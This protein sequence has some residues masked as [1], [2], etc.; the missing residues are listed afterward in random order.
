MEFQIHLKWFGAFASVCLPRSWVCFLH[1]PVNCDNCEWFENAIFTS[2]TV[3]VQLNFTQNIH[4]I[5]LI[6]LFLLFLVF[7]SVFFGLESQIQQKKLYRKCFMLKMCFNGSSYLCISTKPKS[8]VFL[9][10]SLPIFSSIYEEFLKLYALFG[11]NENR[12]F[13]R[14]LIFTWFT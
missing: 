12:I 5:G 10:I 9:D 2:T 13:C 1:S 11:L 3:N 14:R 6:S 7:P 8:L 4:K